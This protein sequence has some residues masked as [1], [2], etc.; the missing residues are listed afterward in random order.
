MEPSGDEEAVIRFSLVKMESVSAYFVTYSLSIPSLVQYTLIYSKILAEL[1]LKMQ[2]YH[3]SHH[4][5]WKAVEDYLS[6]SV[7]S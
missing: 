1:K 4:P 3:T 2:K 7:K 5:S 6:I